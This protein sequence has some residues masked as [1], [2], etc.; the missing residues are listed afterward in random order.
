MRFTGG[1]FRQ[2]AEGARSDWQVPAEV[3]QLLLLSHRPPLGRTTQR[4]ES[5]SSVPA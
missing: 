5:A 3:S 2:A 1:E 4:A